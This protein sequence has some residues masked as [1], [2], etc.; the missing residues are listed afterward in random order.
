MIEVFIR[1]CLSAQKTINIPRS[2]VKQYLGTGKSYKGYI[3]ILVKYN[4]IWI[5][6]KRVNSKKAILRVVDY[7]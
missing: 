6:N 5:F 1:V 3:F 7:A 2:A 4:I